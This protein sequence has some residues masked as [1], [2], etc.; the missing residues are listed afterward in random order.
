M[1]ARHVK[2][3]VLAAMFMGV[4]GIP[5]AAQ[6]PVDSRTPLPLDSAAFGSSRG[7]IIVGATLGSLAGLFVGKLMADQAGQDD[8]DLASFTSAT[9]IAL[10]T[11]TVGATFG[12][13][14]ASEGRITLRRALGGAVL[15]MLGGLTSVYLYD[16]IPAF[17]GRRRLI[18]GYAITQGTIAGLFTSAGT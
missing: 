16:Q 9:P 13:R 18:F 8:E 15:G 4:P 10:V 5:V 11:S 14:V 2:W 7:E 1:G 17:S 3:L 12:M 6:T